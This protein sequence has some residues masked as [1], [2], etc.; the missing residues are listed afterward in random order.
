MPQLLERDVK[1]LRNLLDRPLSEETR[2]ILR[3]A[4]QD[5]GKRITRLAGQLRRTDLEKHFIKAHDSLCREKDGT[6]PT[7]GEVLRKLYVMLP[8]DCVPNDGIRRL[9]R[10]NKKLLLPMSG[11]RGRPKKARTKS[12]LLSKK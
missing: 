8:E 6:L 2:E 10:M 4:V 1:G 11:Q 3:G 9:R 7:Y 12:S 5:F